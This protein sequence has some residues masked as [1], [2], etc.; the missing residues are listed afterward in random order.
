VIV[1]V[2][3]S[4]AWAG[5]MLGWDVERGA[6]NVALIGRQEDNEALSGRIPL[7]SAVIPH[8]ADHPLLGH[9]Y[10]TFWNPARIESFTNN[11]Q[12]LVPDGHSAYIDAA[13]DLGLIGAGFCLFVVM[14]GMRQTAAGYLYDRDLGYGFFLALL[15]CRSLNGLLE[16]NFAAPTSFVPFIM[17]CGL[18]HLAF[19]P[20]PSDVSSPV[21]ST[22]EIES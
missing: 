8:L 9:G 20:R 19:C 10:Q 14:F 5:L 21:D 15:T 13:M 17:V 4:V 3:A 7:W 1:G 12:F 16:S 6:T 11:F 2:I 18:A 22:P